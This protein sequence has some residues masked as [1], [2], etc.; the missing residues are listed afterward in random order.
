MS[1]TAP[2]APARTAWLGTAGYLFAAVAWGWNIPLT[3]RLLQAFDPF[4]LTPWRQMA[5]ALFLGLLVA[6]TLGLAR[7]RTPIAVWRV[8]VLGG[9][10]AGFL[11]LFNLGLKWS[12]P[13]SAAAV[14]AGSP[15]Y[16]AVVNRAMTGARLERGFWGATALTLLGAGIALS[17]R[18][19]GGSGGVHGGE[20]LIVGAI[21][22]WTVYTMLSQRWFQPAEPQLSRTFLAM[23]A[24]VPWTWGAW[25]LAHGLGWVGPP[26]LQPS[27]GDIANVVAAALVCSALAT[28]AWNTGVATLGIQTGAV[29]QNTVPVFA[30][31][32]ALL[33]YGVQPSWQQITGGVVV[34]AGVG[35]MQWQRARGPAARAAPG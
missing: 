1:A 25:V 6:T 22:C 18:V 17:G 12:T 9:C 32:I 19:A 29:W 33:F 23:V 7:L 20:L 10:V 26:N 3:G 15:V 34:L 14:I 4:W 31:L 28:V 11:A 21:A 16:V 5:S 24:A 35:Y 2:A 27:T 30:V 8:A 13:L